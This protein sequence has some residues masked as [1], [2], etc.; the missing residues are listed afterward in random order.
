MQKWYQFV[1]LLLKNQ[2]SG[3][4][5][6]HWTSVAITRYRYWRG[7]GKEELPLVK[8]F[9]KTAK[10]V[11]SSRQLKIYSLPIPT[12]KKWDTIDEKG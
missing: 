3:G 8:T 7:D 6:Y 10:Y 5:R 2:G 12:H 11:D 4:A 9:S 1:P